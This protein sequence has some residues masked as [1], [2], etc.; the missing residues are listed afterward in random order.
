ML[1]R[2]ITRLQQGWFDGA[3]CWHTDPEKLADLRA[4][5]DALDANPGSSLILLDTTGIP[6]KVLAAVGV[7][8]VDNAECVGVTVGGLNTRVS[9]SVLDMTNQAARQRDK[10][11]ELRTAAHRTNPDAVASI[12]WLGY[13]APDSLRDVTHDWHARDGADR[14]NR[15][16]KGLAASSNVADQH[17]TGFGHSY[18]S[19]VTSLALQ[20]GAPVSDV[21]L[22]GSPG[23]EL[24]DASQLRVRPGH[25]FYLVGVNDYV[26][27]TIPGFGAFGP[28]L[29]NVPGMTPLSTGTDLAPPNEYGDGQLHERAYGHSDYARLGSNGQLRMSAYNMAAVLAGLPDDLIRPRQL[30]R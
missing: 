23:G 26:A 22:Y 2:E 30:G 10:A 18:G 11:G 4:L 14:L 13:D 7:G 9:A 28:A 25:A 27:E 3:G 24:T 16:Y 19:L 12:A 8:D 21:V 20:Q 17:I 29:Q 1:Q 6:G 15:F 5:R